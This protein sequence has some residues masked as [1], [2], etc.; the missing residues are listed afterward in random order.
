[1]GRLDDYKKYMKMPDKEKFNDTLSFDMNKVINKS[2]GSYRISYYN[3]LNGQ[4][5][6]E[7]KK[8]LLKHLM[9]GP[10][11]MEEFLKE[12]GA[13]NFAMDFD[14]A[15]LAYAV[16]KQVGL[17]YYLKSKETKKDKNG[18]PIAVKYE[19]PGRKAPNANGFYDLDPADKEYSFWDK[20]CDFFGYKTDH[21]SKVDFYNFTQQAVN[22]R[23]QELEL[24]T[25]KEL[26]KDRINDIV[27]KGKTAQEER[28]AKIKTLTDTEKKWEKLFFGDQ[29]APAYKFG[30]GYR[31]ISGL[32]AC[33]AIFTKANTYD[34]L[35]Q[36]QKDSNLLDQVL[37]G[38]AEVGGFKLEDFRNVGKNF[39]DLCSQKEKT[40]KEKQEAEKYD[41]LKDFMFDSKKDK[42][43]PTP[44]DVAFINS[45]HNI[46]GENSNAIGDNGPY[47]GYNDVK[48]EDVNL[49]ND[50]AYIKAK[51]EIDRLFGSRIKIFG[52]KTE[53]DKLRMEPISEMANAVKIYENLEK[54]QFS[55]MNKLLGVKDATD[56]SQIL[57]A[58]EQKLEVPAKVMEKEE[59]YNENDF[60]R[61]M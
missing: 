27:E 19:V 58:A 44:E 4:L 49:Q 15:I 28:K 23:I 6:Q 30:L 61:N 47:E 48:K 13:S 40:I 29:K 53:A 11:T 31:E 32:T 22:E 52:P 12:M 20:F 35:G 38:K 39:A 26:N 18:N 16:E 7:E 9:V 43:A 51:Q 34:A 24:E 2:D 55:G 5:N 25:N 14:P 50:Y 41:M 60:E 21:A 54:G 3:R 8:N 37:E 42:D 59:P 10:L 33:M 36:L 57:D 1:M 45:I 46:N 56:I 17:V